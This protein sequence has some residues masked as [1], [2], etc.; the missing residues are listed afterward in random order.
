[1]SG[2]DRLVGAITDHS[3][4]VIVALLVVSVVVGAGAANV[5]QSSSL[6]QFQSD[7]KEAQK[8]DYI[9][10]NFTTGDTNTTSVQVI[11]R[12]GNVLRQE[13]LVS[14]LRFQQELRANE[15][16][17]DTLAAESPTTGIANVITTT[18]IRQE[19]GQDLQ[20]R[21]Q[22][23]ETRQQEL[24]RTAARLTS[25]LN[26]TRELQRQ[27]DQLNRSHA[28]GEINNETYAQRTEQIEQQ[29]TS[30]RTEATTNLSANQS[31]QFTQLTRQARTLQHQLD[32]LNASYQAGEINQS[33]YERRAGEIQQQFQQVYRD[34][35]SI[36]APE[37]QELQE[38]TEALQADRTALENAT[39]SG[40]MPSL[41][42]QI[43]QLESM[44]QSEINSVITTVLSD[45]QNGG[46][47]GAFV[48]MPTSYEPGSTSAEATMLV[49]SQ[50]AE[51]QAIEGMATERIE[52][53]QLAIQEKANDRFGEQAALVFGSGIISDEINR[54]MTD[55]LAI[56]GPLALLF[57]L[58]VLIIAYR[59]PIDILLGLLGIGIVLG[60][61][62]GF[63]GWLDIAFNQIMIAV[64][65]LLIGLSID[66]A[67]HVFMRH[68]EERERHDETANGGARVRGSMKTALASVGV[69]LTWVTATTVIGFL[70]NL[71][72][73]IPPIQDFGVVSAFGIVAAL[74]V[75]GALIPALKV[76]IDSLLEARGVDR[77]KRA[78]GASGGRVSDLLTGGTTLA[79]RAPFAVIAIA[80]LVSAGGAY[81]ATQVDTSFAQEDFLAE[82]P[83]GWMED[84]PEPFKPGE[85]TAKSSL[86]Y[87]NDKF[88][89]QDSQAQILVEGQVTDPDTLERMDRA[90]DRAAES[91]I[92]VVLSNGEA[93][94]RSPLTVMRAVAAENES[95]N[96]TFIDS[97]MN[98]DGVPDRN[99]E[100]V[101][102][103]LYE[104]APDQAASVIYRTDDGEYQALRMTVSLQGGASSDAVADQMRD[105]AAIVDGSGLDATA[106]GQPI[107]F[108]LVQDQLLDT[109]I[110]SLLITL[111]AVFAF[112]MLMYRI[113]DG[114]ATLGFVT[115]LP[116]VLSVMWILGTMYLADIPF[117]VLTGMI[118]SL[119]VGLGVAYSIHISERYAHEL[120]RH[121]SVWEAM[122]TTVT[123]TGGAL[124]GSAATTVG[125][126]GVLVFAILP[127]LQQF[128]LI[129]G[130]TIIYAFLASVLVLPSLLV[131][132]TRYLGP[133]GV[134]T[135]ETTS[136][137]DAIPASDGGEYDG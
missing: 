32:Q 31:A 16:I 122:R 21:S 69:A 83:P 34:V 59:D 109:V 4:W 113:T 87:V 49:V 38:D 79:R 117:N 45:G 60:W 78:F 106:T 14:Q 6:E 132:W 126:F 48:F 124:L 120:E 53:S 133:D 65:V 40:E 62:F 130:L 15:T 26:E 114:S 3:R 137:E 73:S 91:N 86:N 23:L 47:N 95:F 89:R 92:R 44:N 90:Q 128:G 19:Q 24:N 88:L 76:E 43:E 110:Q 54:S 97:D 116:V 72:S 11:V 74:L 104:T 129:T 5:E 36:L 127:P 112:L 121:A 71:T 28:R 80:L 81:G 35:Q 42:A 56:V 1:M 84:L 98:G 131:V 68:R 85:Y 55:S 67:I 12:D 102:D 2:G 37:Y 29:L 101:Y 123:G 105:V 10:S 107:V 118:T 82:E 51:Q 9:E 99:L 66:Y 136:S 70:S 13:A 111:V 33:T 57:V 134:F 52:T 39:A 25:A 46:G 20:Q 17:N 22:A 100:R 58:L 63:M 125:G 75:F 77:E 27:Y 50:T 115:L 96:A 93:D 41:S 30:V 64:P 103:A 8:L 18:A 7:T 135:D 108:K 119:T 61:T 94:V